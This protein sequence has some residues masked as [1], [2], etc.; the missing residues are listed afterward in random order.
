MK[1]ALYVANS[2]CNE[3]CNKSKIQLHSYVSFLGGKKLGAQDGKLLLLKG[4]AA[5]TG[6]ARGPK[7]VEIKS[8][9]TLA[10]QEPRKGT[11]QSGSQQ[12]GEENKGEKCKQKST[13]RAVRSSIWRTIWERSASHCICISASC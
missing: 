11:S 4:S 10:C 6:G 2:F 1:V 5:S 13:S 3:A 12:P 9:L 7:A 8:Q